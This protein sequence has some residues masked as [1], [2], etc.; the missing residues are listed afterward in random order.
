MNA[1]T[2]EL[3][4]TT[5]NMNATR[6][7]EYGAD[8]AIVEYRVSVSSVM[9]D[10]SEGRRRTGGCW[11]RAASKT[12][13]SKDTKTFSIQRYTNLFDPKIRKPFG[14]IILTHRTHDIFHAASII[15]RE[16][17]TRTPIRMAGTFLPTPHNKLQKASD[18]T[19]TWMCWWLK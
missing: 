6:R 3:A 15:W 17:R 16:L 11:R 14:S 13:W 19:H 5:A 18:D 10:V 2:G 12:F 9:H 4:D 7:N 8:L 1:A